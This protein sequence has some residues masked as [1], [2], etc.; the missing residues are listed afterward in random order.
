MMMTRR[1]TGSRQRG[2]FAALRTHSFVLAALISAPLS[3]FAA[4]TFTDVI[5]QDALLAVWTNDFASLKEG[6]K[7]SPYG[8]LWNDPSMEKLRNL[9]DVEYKKLQEEGN[10]KDFA[11]LSQ[12]AEILKG[13]VAFYMKQDGETFDPEKLNFT[14][15]VEID[16]AGKK[17]LDEKL[18]DFGSEVKDG[19]KDSFETNGV[20]VYRVKGV[21][22]VEAEIETPE[23]DIL[24]KMNPELSTPTPQPSPTPAPTLE[25]TTIQYAYVGD[26]YFVYSDANNEAI[27]KEAINMLK[28]TTTGKGIGA[29]EDMRL[30]TSKTVSGPAQFNAFVDTGKLFASYIESDKEIDDVVKANISK[31]GL[32]DIKSVY[33]TGTLGEK[34]MDLDVA[35]S[36]PTEK[37]GLVKALFAG[38][39]T[40]LAMTKYVP[41]DVLTFTSFSLDLGA[42]YD[43]T[44]TIIESFSPESAGMAKMMIASSSADYEV[45]VVNSILR[46]ISGEHLVTRSALNEEIKKQLEP[47]AAMLTSSDAFYFGLKNGDQTVTALKALVAKLKSK[48]ETAESLD[49]SE[50]EGITV[51]IPKGFSA[52]ESPIKPILAFNKDALVYCNNEVQLQEVLRAL[53]GKLASPLT[54]QDAYKSLVGSLKKDNMYSLTYSPKGSIRDG[55]NQLREMADQGFLDNL[56]GFEADMIPTAEVAEKYFGDSYS[57]IYSEEKVLYIQT[58]ILG[59]KQ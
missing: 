55:I 8:K 41:S 43:A 37:N 9:V 15:I 50:R 48:P 14:G 54:A 11:E 23:P 5:P 28:D 19:K 25:E 22:A 58:K 27:V 2:S 38:G 3:S 53:N 34:S 49:V 6:A 16:E 12:V 30:L 39:P 57:G 32:Y 51:V 17:W 35:V 52:E 46:N 42:I 44:M 10:E 21:T 45:D 13:G 20:T 33:V 26:K 31:T 40:P 47:E 36:T 7:V 4:T 1:A 56:E 18:K 24:S 59:P 29:R